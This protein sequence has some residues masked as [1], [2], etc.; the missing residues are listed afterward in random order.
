MRLL[1]HLRDESDILEGWIRHYQRLGV[2]SLHL[3]VHGGPTQNARLFGLLGSAPITIEE[4]VDG[5]HD[6]REKIARLQRVAERYPGEWLVLV[7]GDEL[8]EVPYEDL[9]TTAARLDRVGANALQAPFLQRVR[10]DGLLDTPE[11]L[12]DPLA[13]LPLAVPGLIAALGSGA[14]ETKFPLLRVDPGLAIRGGNHE[15]PFGRGTL[16]SSARGVTHHVKWRRPL[17]ARMAER[18]ATGHTHRHES[19]C[20]LDWLRAHAGTLPLHGAFRCT[21]EE[22]FQRGLLRRASF[23]DRARLWDRARRRRREL[24]AAGAPGTRVDR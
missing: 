1:C 8:L 2:S 21:R 23:W 22:L 14:C 10:A 7:D 15:P 11:V 19:E 3:I 5:P 17:L 9:P 24:G 13:E 18:I 12:D 4:R 16:L 6:E 20:Y